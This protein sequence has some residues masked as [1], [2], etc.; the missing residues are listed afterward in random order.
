MIHDRYIRC[1]P[2]AAL[3]VSAAVAVHDVYASPPRVIAPVSV[4]ALATI[5]RRPAELVSSST[6]LATASTPTASRGA[7]KPFEGFVLSKALR[8]SIVAIAL[9]VFE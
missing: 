2:L 5:D 3:S 4:S 9:T 8:D 6:E 1:W 7:V